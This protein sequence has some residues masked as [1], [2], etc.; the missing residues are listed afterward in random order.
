MCKKSKM[1]RESLVCGVVPICIAG[2]M[3]GLHAYFE[4]S[5]HSPMLGCVGRSLYL[6]ILSASRSLLVGVEICR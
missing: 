6:C 2:R 5:S 1:S 4:I 3:E